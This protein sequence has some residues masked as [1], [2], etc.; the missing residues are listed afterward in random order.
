MTIVGEGRGALLLAQ[1]ELITDR[2]P[3][4]LRIEH[5]RNLT[6]KNVIIARDLYG[7]ARPFFGSYTVDIESSTNITFRH[8]YVETPDQLAV[9]ALTS[10][11]VVIEDSTIRGVGSAGVYAGENERGRPAV[12]IRNSRIEGRQLALEGEGSVGCGLGDPKASRPLIVLSGSTV[13]SGGTPVSCP[14]DAG[15][16]AAWTIPEGLLGHHLEE[17]AVLPPVDDEG[18][19]PGSDWPFCIDSMIWPLFPGGPSNIDWYGYPPGFPG[20]AS[21]DAVHF[22]GWSHVLDRRKG[23]WT[24]FETLGGGYNPLASVTVWQRDE[25]LHTPCMLETEGGKLRTHV[26]SAKAVEAIDAS[27]VAIV[28]TADPCGVKPLAEKVLV[29]RALQPAT[30][31]RWRLVCAF[32][33]EALRCP[34]AYAQPVPQGIDQPKPFGSDRPRSDPTLRGPVDPSVPRPL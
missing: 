9:R 2:P 23:G 19:Q 29:P 33:Q 10:T 34:E 11:G 5:C 1:T 26:F 13:V 12:V 7:D 16:E 6:F 20:C 31:R 18:P 21:F 17:F 32:K 4:A 14:A 30:S 24:R 25:N 27:R 3:P 22:P 8:V 15:T 28:G